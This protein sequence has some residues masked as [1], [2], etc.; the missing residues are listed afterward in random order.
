MEYE[1]ETDGPVHILY[2]EVSSMLGAPTTTKTYYSDGKVVTEVF[3]GSGLH[4]PFEA[5]R[6]ELQQESRNLSETGVDKHRTV[7][8]ICLYMAAFAIILTGIAKIL[9]VK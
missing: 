1:K 3:P 8:V 6:F 2:M 4:Y 5:Q 7:L 9:M